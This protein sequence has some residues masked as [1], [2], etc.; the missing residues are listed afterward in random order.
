MNHIPTGTLRLQLAL[1]ANFKFTNTVQRISLSFPG[2]KCVHKQSPF[3]LL[4]LAICCLLQLPCLNVSNIFCSSGIFGSNFAQPLTTASLQPNWEAFQARKWLATCSAP[5]LDVGESRITN[6]FHLLYLVEFFNFLSNFLSWSRV[7]VHPC[8]KSWDSRTLSSHQCRQDHC[9]CDDDARIFKARALRERGKEGH[10]A[11]K[12]FTKTYPP[13]TLF[14][15]VQPW[16]KRAPS[17]ASVSL[18]PCWK[19]IPFLPLGG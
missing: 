16:E 1:N 3:S 12:V 6:I 4:I 2:W 17:C 10:A 5:Y 11:P 19:C 13:A 14:L 15:C 9:P 7:S 8:Y 18:M